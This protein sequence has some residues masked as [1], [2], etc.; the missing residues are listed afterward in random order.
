MIETRAENIIKYAE[1]VEEFTVLQYAT[2]NEPEQLENAS[3]M[4]SIANSINRLVRIGKLQRVRLGVF[5]KMKYNRWQVVL[6]EQEKAVY[7]LIHAQ[8]PLVKVCV[9]NGET[10]A[11]LQHHLAFNQATYIEVERDSVES[12]FHQL[13]DTGY[14]VS[15]CPDEQMAYD[16]VDV[17]KKIVVVKALVSQAPLAR[18]EGYYVPT[19]EK[20]LVDIRKDKDFYY[21]QGIE[22]S[23]MTDTA[24]QM[25]VINEQKLRRYAKRRN[26]AM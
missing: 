20:L 13:Q 17:K 26:V 18:Q 1:T 8:Y 21:M 16:Y 19:L 24:R 14:E 25:Y 5:V 15:C 10:I 3:M 7:D 22:A 2:V 12:V 4:R 6:G 9:Y 23:Y 11:P